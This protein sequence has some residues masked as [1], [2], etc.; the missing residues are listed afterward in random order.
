MILL[1]K[2]ED[3]PRGHRGRFP[4]LANADVANSRS[5]A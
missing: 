3:R 2:G 5:D 1:K 4:F